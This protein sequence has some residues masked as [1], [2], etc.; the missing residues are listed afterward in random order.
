[1]ANYYI[2]H[3]WAHDEQLAE[4]VQ[5]LSSRDEPLNCLVEVVDGRIVVTMPD[6]DNYAFPTELIIEV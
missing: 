5:K 4:L 3:H 2:Q 6:L 1:M